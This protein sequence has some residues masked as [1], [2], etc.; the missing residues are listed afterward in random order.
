MKA[1]IL[2]VYHEGRFRCDEGVTDIWLPMAEKKLSGK[3]MSPPEEKISENLKSLH[4][5]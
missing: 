2:L 1:Y 4:Q 5:I 3:L